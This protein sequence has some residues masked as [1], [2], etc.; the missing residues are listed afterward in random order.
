MILVVAEGGVKVLEDVNDEGHQV[1]DTLLA[2]RVN[3]HLQLLIDTLSKGLSGREKRDSEEYRREGGKEK[4]V[5][6]R[7]REREGRGREG[8]KERESKK[9]ILLVPGM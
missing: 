3:H 2:V 4:R 8:E 5:R 1:A 9:C 7:E 6:E